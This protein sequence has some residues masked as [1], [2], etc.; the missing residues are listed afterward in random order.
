MGEKV[1]FLQNFS[2]LR[3]WLAFLSKKKTFFSCKI[4]DFAGLGALFGTFFCHFFVIFLKSANPAGRSARGLTRDAKAVSGKPEC[5][6]RCGYELV[7][8]ASFAPHCRPP[9]PLLW[10]K[11]SEVKWVLVLLWYIP[12]YVTFVYSSLPGNAYGSKSA[13]GGAAQSNCTVKRVEA[14]AESRRL[15]DKMP[16]TTSNLTTIMIPTCKQDGSYDEVRQPDLQSISM[17]SLCTDCVVID[18]FCHKIPS[19]APEA[20]KY[21]IYL[22]F[23]VGKCALIFI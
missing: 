4:S 13:P 17:F 10:K 11:V 12:F 23:L 8:P 21:F 14:L 1:I 16:G 5:T 15:S 19:M 3:G 6:S 9:T 18:Y 22:V 20:S 2:F 7:W